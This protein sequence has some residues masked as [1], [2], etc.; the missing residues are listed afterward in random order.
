V[1]SGPIPTVDELQALSRDM[2]Q[3]ANEMNEVRLH[4]F[5]K[6]ALSS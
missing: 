1:R 4:G 3:I 6:D 5:L 2:V